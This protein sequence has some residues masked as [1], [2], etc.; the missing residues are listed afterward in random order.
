MRIW[1]NPIQFEVKK[2][3][4][5]VEL[6][7]SDL[8][9]ISQ[10]GPEVGNLSI[11]GEIVQGLYGGP[12]L[13]RSDYVYVPAYVKKILGAG[14]RLAKIDVATLEVELLGKTKDLIFLDRVEGSQIY[15]FEDLDRSIQSVYNL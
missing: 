3:S 13:C 11:N 6:V 15:F 4:G 7:Y 8:M 12:A 1:E 2:K 9:E 5:N 14:F 10:G